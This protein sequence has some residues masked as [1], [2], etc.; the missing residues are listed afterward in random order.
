MISHLKND[1]WLVRHGRSK[2][3]DLGIIV[4]DP[5]HGIEPD[6]GLTV[7]GEKQAEKAGND[8]LERIPDFDP[9]NFHIYYSPFSR[10]Q[11]TAQEIA[12]VIGIETNGEGFNSEDDLRERYFGDEFELETH[13]NYHVVW[14]GDTQNPHDEPE[15]GGESVG[16]VSDRLKKLVERLEQQHTGQTIVL[17]SHGDV[18]SILWATI[19]GLPLNNHR[20]YGMETGEVRQLKSA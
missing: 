15:G 8:L 7:E 1:Y 9:F 10:T 19:H 4:S 18:L 20:K 6:Y 2:A 17:V 5:E 3:N 14:E 12:R 11:E 16:E 13:D